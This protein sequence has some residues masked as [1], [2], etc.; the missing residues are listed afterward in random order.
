MASPKLPGL[1]LVAAPPL[2]DPN[3]VEETFANQMVGIGVADGIVHLTLSVV[4]ARHNNNPGGP[5]GNENIVTMRPV[6]PL[7]TMNALVEAYGQLQN[8]LRMQQTIKP[9]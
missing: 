3:H 2:S 9:N 1:Q 7:A 8:A 4:R 5:S 6:M